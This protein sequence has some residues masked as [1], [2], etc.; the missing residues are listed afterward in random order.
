M[1][2]AKPDLSLPLHANRPEQFRVSHIDR[3]DQFRIKFRL[4]LGYEPLR[5]KECIPRGEPVRA[6]DPH[7]FAK[8]AQRQPQGQ[9]AAQGVPI[10]FL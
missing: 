7:L 6:D 9:P 8:R 10:R 1:V 3:H 2:D 5:V 4:L